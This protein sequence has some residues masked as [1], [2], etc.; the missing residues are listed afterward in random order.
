M[1]RELKQAEAARRLSE[2]RLAD[3]IESISEG[4][5][6]FDG[7]DRLIVC[8]GRYREFYPGLADMIAPGTPY[9]VIARTAAE[10]GLVRDAVGRV[11]EWLEQRLALHRNPSG[12]HLE[13]QSDGRWIQI[14]E[15]RTS[16]G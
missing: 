13:A 10:Q 2:Q 6:L 16:D 12:P 1:S 4:F 3:A 11:D 7:E 8:N 14:S 5:A 15:R 9:A